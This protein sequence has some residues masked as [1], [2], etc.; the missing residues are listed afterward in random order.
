MA[1]YLVTGGG[2]FIGGHLVRAL[3]AGGHMVRVLDDFSTGSR[4]RVPAQV[5]IHEGSICDSHAV[6]TAMQ[7]VD[8]V[9]HLAAI[10][11]VER[12]TQE[13]VASHRVNLDGALEVFV[14]A[15]KMD[16]PVVYASS[17]AIYGA[18]F[19]FPITETSTPMPSSAYGADKLGCEHHARALALTRGLRSVGLRFFN[20]YGEG[21]DP[22]SPYSGVISIF[23]RRLAEKRPVKIFGDGTATR[24]FVAVEDVVDAMVRCMGRLSESNQAP[25]SPR[26]CHNVFNVCTGVPTSVNALFGLIARIMNSEQAADYEPARPGEIHQSLGDPSSLVHW[27]GL[28]SPRPLSQGLAELFAGKLR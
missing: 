5:P 2:G 3:L 24:D 23:G 22:T 25:A 16:V 4:A 28:P 8:G 17:A 20:V 12:C 21:Q 11:S 15:A 19:V 7:D 1:I 10:A 18:Q 26:G 27:C 6:E 9:F 14:R 13:L